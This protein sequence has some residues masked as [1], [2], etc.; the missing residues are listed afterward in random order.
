MNH[1]YV[2]TYIKRTNLLDY[3]RSNHDDCAEQY[4]YNAERMKQ[5]YAEERD[6]RL[7]LL[8]RHEDGRTLCKIKCPIN[9]LPVKGEF[10]V[11]TM[12]ALH[13]FLEVNGWH[14]S[15]VLSANLLK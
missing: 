12:G 10:E 14:K 7:I 4:N 3:M 9:P 11:P 8:V 5:Y 13:Y 6:V 1:Q 2:V 15:G